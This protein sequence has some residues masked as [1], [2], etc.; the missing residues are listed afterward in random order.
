[1]DLIIAA[2]SGVMKLNLPG[3][4]FKLE[5]YIAYNLKYAKSGDY[6]K[7]A[8]QVYRHRQSAVAVHKC[9]CFVLLCSC[10]IHG[11]TY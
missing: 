6:L 2:G 4:V 3:M 8:W 5:D 7:Y 1:M 9:H 11:R 10:I